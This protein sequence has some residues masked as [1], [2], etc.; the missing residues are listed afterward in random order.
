MSFV[1]FY[2]ILLFFQDYFEIEKKQEAKTCLQFLSISFLLFFKS[3]I[4]AVARA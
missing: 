3:F 1:Y 4:Y 2:F